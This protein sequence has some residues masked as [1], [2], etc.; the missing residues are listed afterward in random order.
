MAICGAMDFKQYDASTRFHVFMVFLLFYSF[1]L[2]SFSFDFFCEWHKRLAPS[3]SLFRVL[4]LGWLLWIHRSYSRLTQK[5]LT[6]PYFLWNFIYVKNEATERYTME[7][8]VKESKWKR[9][10]SLTSG[11]ES[12]NVVSKTSM[13]SWTGLWPLVMRVV[14]GLWAGIAESRR[15]D[16]VANYLSRVQREVAGVSGTVVF[17]PFGARH[18]QR[19]WG[20]RVPSSRLFR[21]HGKGPD[22]RRHRLVIQGVVHWAASIRRH[23][24]LILGKNWAARPGYRRLKIAKHSRNR[25]ARV[26]CSEKWEKV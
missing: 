25:V 4:L 1:F 3:V 22:V 2:H 19:G 20:L 10:S 7:K 14:T 9:E 12:T 21:E 16:E 26:L 15:G 18:I 17:V 23:F 8:V 24:Q 6:I 5:K 11:W 13:V